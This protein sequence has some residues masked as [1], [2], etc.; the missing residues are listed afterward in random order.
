MKHLIT[1][2]TLSLLIAI[3]SQT[4]AQTSAVEYMELIG[5][6]YQTIAKA[7]WKYTSTVAHSKSA[8]KMDRTRRDLIKT[9][10]KA[11]KNVQKL[12][13]WE[14][15]TAYR[16][17]VLEYLKVSYNVLVQ[18]YSKLMDLEEVAEQSYDGMEAY[19]LMQK[20]A[21]K[22]MKNAQ[23]MVQRT[24]VDFCAK[25][26]ITLLEDDSEMSKNM[27]IAGK[28][29]DHYNE[30]YLIFF[31]ASVQETNLLLAMQRKD[32]AAMQQA[33]SALLQFST[34]GLAKLDT[35]SS[36]KGDKNMI[37]AAQKVLNFY[38]SEAE[39][40]VQN[41]AEFFLFTEKFD[42]LRGEMEAKKNRTQKDVDEYNAAVAD[43]NKESNS[44]NSLN[45]KLNKKR[46]S[47]ID[48][49]NTKASAFTDRHVPKG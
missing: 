17:S 33:K 15:N 18:D 38:K 6:E 7:S 37:Y 48:E 35:L 10:E 4:F 31:K 21:N 24:Q 41:L 14:G 42:K 32:V 26:N 13:G 1:S 30:V 47:L 43:Y 16:D 40:D 39:N 27:A 9:T 22:K 12:A 36:F 34:E 23:D 49:W 8:R 2:I 29:Y 46:A 3:S 19:L 44:F 5:E 11:Q 45:D 28:V 25:N 20:L